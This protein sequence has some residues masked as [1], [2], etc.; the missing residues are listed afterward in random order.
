VNTTT[1]GASAT[2]LAQ[3]RAELS[4]LPDTELDEVLEDVAD[5]LEEIGAELDG[6]P[7]MPALQARLGTPGEYA[8]ELRTAAGY[9]PKAAAVEGKNPGSA[10]LRW[11]IAATV[12]T[13]VLIWFWFGAGLYWSVGGSLLVL[14]VMALLSALGIRAL[15]GEDPRIVTTTRLWQRGEAWLQ[16]QA[17]R[18]PDGVRRDLVVVGQPAWWVVRGAAAG[19]LLLVLTGIE[20]GLLAVIAGL[21]GAV[22]SIWVG[23]R[24]QQDRRWLWFVVPAN[25]VGIVA[26]L[27]LVASTAYWSPSYAYGGYD[28]SGNPHI[29]GL[30]HDGRP[31]SNVFLF[32]Q[33]GKPLTD[34]RLYDETGAPLNVSLERCAPTNDP[35][36]I[37]VDVDNVFP[38]I[39]VTRTEYDGT[40][41]E[42]AGPVFTV[43]PLKPSPTPVPTKPVPTKPVPTP[44]R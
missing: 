29:P 18:L 20:D 14:A 42:S 43:P 7:T 6:E 19:I 38:K 5:H 2:Y 30:A 33:Q 31:I 11:A 37:P 24:S 10:A 17:A 32:D 35:V 41:H 34:V 26:V 1:T 44:T 8:E 23:R 28:S 9:P 40:C 3:V 21:L 13:P 36:S 12:A 25:V 22:A 4:D 27:G 16:R 39:T 15:R